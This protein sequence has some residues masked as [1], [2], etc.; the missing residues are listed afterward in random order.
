MASVMLDLQLPTQLQSDTDLWLVSNYA[1][2]DKYI[3]RVWTTCPELL[4]RHSLTCSQTIDVFIT[5]VQRQPIAPL[6]Y[7]PTKR[8]SIIC[9]ICMDSFQNSVA[10]CVTA[11]LQLRGF[12]FT[13]FIQWLWRSRSCTNASSTNSTV[14]Y[15]PTGSDALR[16]GS[17]VERVYKSL[18]QHK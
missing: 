9:I 11:D 4:R 14:W 13:I 7:P 10:S 5:Q 17:T 16:P 18:M 2:C 12:E 6:C 3:L 15:W 8:L 1:T